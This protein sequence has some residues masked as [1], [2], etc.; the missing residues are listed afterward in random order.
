MISTVGVS[1]P[2]VTV[3]IPAYSSKYISQAVGSVLAQTFQDFEIVVV[4]DGSPETDALEQA[5]APYQSRIR[6]ISQDNAGGAAAR[7]TAVRA[8]RTPL[9][10][11]LDHDDMLEPEHLSTQVN[12]MLEH[13]EIDAC[14]VN[15]LYFGGS[16]LDGSYW[17]DQ[18]PSEGAVSFLSVME[19][20]TCPAN[21]GAIIRRDT[22]M[23]L[24]LYDPHVDSWDDFDMWL[25]ILH[26]G[27]RMAYQKKPLVRYRLHGGNLSSRRLYFLERALRVLDKVDANMRLSTEEAAA[28][29]RRRKITAFELEML[30]GKEAIS[31]REW[32]TAR[33]HFEYCAATSPSL[34]LRSVLLALRY[35]PWLLPAALGVR[36]MKNSLSR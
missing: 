20:R 9:I 10:V 8:A 28:V 30:R 4:N 13:P 25:R 5:L 7:N 19:G 17:M 21:P 1:D 16:P 26:A 12:F 11:N 31:R 34:K 15:S 32:N 22:I 27:G 24:G 36:Q 33:R 29:A 14:Y 6:Y 3:A 18:N 2:L 23:R 35:F